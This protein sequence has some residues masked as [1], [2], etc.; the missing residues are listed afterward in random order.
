MQEVVKRV[1]VKAMHQLADKIDAGNCELT[2]EEATEI[3]SVIVHEPLT[4][5]QACEYLNISRAQFDNHVANGLIPKGI[6]R[7]GSNEL[8]WYKDELNKFSSTYKVK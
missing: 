4:K 5:V 2:E 6:K 7:K 3:M 8:R 1:L